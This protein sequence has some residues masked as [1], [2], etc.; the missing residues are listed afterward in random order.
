MTVHGIARTLPNGFHDAFLRGFT[1]DYL[2]RVAI[3]DIEAWTGDLRSDTAKVRDTYR[4]LTL[5]VTG[6]LICH[7]ETPDLEALY[8]VDR[9]QDI[10]LLPERLTFDGLTLVSNELPVGASCCTFAFT[11][12]HNSYIHIAAM[13]AVSEWLD[14]AH[15]I[16]PFDDAPVLPHNAFTSSDLFAP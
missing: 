3:F 6:L 2:R 9:G 13:D 12:Q 5:T 16:Y 8:S 11:Q 7:I 14:E 10:D 15:P 1:V 4:R